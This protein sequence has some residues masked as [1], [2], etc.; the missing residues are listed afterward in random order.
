MTRLRLHCVP[1]LLIFIAG[2][3]MV[4]AEFAQ[5][6]VNLSIIGMWVWIP[7]CQSIFVY[8]FPVRLLCA[9]WGPLW[10]DLSSKEPCR[11][12]THKYLY[13]ERQSHRPHWL[14][15]ARREI[16]IVHFIIAKKYFILS[17]VWTL[18]TYKFHMTQ[19]FHYTVNATI[20][21][22]KLSL[23]SFWFYN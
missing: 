7:P 9:G 5:S 17:S 10:N 1:Y 8:L 18:R 13:Q 23:V 12:S 4:M 2:Y 20:H 16:Q 15:M 14:T 22:V 3:V 19:F 6:F 11:K 21:N